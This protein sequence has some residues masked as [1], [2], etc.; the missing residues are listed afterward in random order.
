MFA[1]DDLYSDD[2]SGLED[3]RIVSISP[4]FNDKNTLEFN[5]G[6]DKRFLKF[7]ATKL[8]FSVEIPSNYV[9]DND[10]F[11]KLVENTE[12]CI[13]HESITRKSSQLD[14]SV[15][16]AMLNKVSYDDSFLNTSLKT[17]GIFESK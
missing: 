11:A 5:L 8:E 14:N 17:H 1:Y 10:V 4:L 6:P 12:I 15:T 13:N 9:L 2:N 7:S 3:A 16:S